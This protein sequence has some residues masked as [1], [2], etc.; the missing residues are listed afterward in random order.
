MILWWDTH[1]TEDA[2]CDEDYYRPLG[3]ILA[4]KS[5]HCWWS[6][7]LLF[8]ASTHKL[9]ID[10][11]VIFCFDRFW[12]WFFLISTSSPLEVPTLFRIPLKNSLGLTIGGQC[13]QKRERKKTIR[14][15]KIF[16]FIKIEKQRKTKQNYFNLFN[17]LSSGFCNGNWSIKFYCAITFP[18]VTNNPYAD[19][20]V[21]KNENNT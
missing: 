3:F 11:F 13:K 10:S 2:F 17:V 14:K 20:V 15:F 8:Y 6:L 16:S 7:G 5:T 9:V 18:M 4:T 12:K 1:I 21:H 19:D